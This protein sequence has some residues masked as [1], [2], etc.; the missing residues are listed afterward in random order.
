MYQP[1]FAVYIIVLIRRRV[2]EIYQ[3][4][5]DRKYQEVATMTN[6]IR[7]RGADIETAVND[8]PYALTRWPDSMQMPLD[9][10]E[11]NATI[12]TWNVVASAFTAEE[13]HSD[14]SLE[15]TFIECGP[16]EFAIA[17]DNLHVR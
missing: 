15:L 8:Y 1:V 12:P 11:V 7:L 6:G 16:G 9:T 17:L 2:E 14:L 4:L 13:Q 3:L 10:I 5:V